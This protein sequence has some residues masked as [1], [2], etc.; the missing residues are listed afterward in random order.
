M[1]DSEWATRHRALPNLHAST[2][3]LLPLI[4]LKFQ[5]KSFY[6]HHGSPPWTYAMA[7]I[8]FY[9]L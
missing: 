7:K 3:N 4:N 9:G 8:T 1:N 2:V 6:V 5:T